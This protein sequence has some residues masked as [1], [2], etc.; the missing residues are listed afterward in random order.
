MHCKPFLGETCRAGIRKLF[1]F[2]KGDY[3]IFAPKPIGNIKLF[4]TE[5]ASDKKGCIKIGPCGLG[6]RAVYLNSFFLDR[7]CYITYGDIRRIYKRIAMTKNGFS[8]K[9]AFG[10]MPYLVV[11]KSDGTEKQCNFKYEYEVDSFINKF[12]ETHPGIPIFSEAG[13]KRLAEE[14][15]REE[16]RYVKNLSP[17]ALSS[18]AELERA[19]DFLRSDPAV[20]DELSR[21]AK[22]KRIIDNIKPAYK[23]FA[24]VIL[25]FSA[26]ACIY[27]IYSV[28]NG[29]GMS[30]YF[31]L[32]GFAFMF[33][34]MSMQ[35]LP[36]AKN[37]SKAAMREFKKAVLASEEFISRYNNSVC[38]NGKVCAF[39]LPAQYAHPAAISRMIRIIREGRA[40]D[41]HS[42]YTAMKDELKTINNTV[43]VSQTE[44]DEITAV[45]PMFLICG[46]NDNFNINEVL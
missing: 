32:F 33:Y 13:E 17:E 16:K 36:T 34:A 5:L 12:H 37:N 1:D 25:A 31:I 28:M 9:G 39:P 29:S 45:K 6:K 44:Y 30:V 43:K 19:A 7:V 14:R 8:G 3:M 2:I 26:A 18:I 11:L 35:V 38:G 27:G 15:A 21:T 42:A 24:T 10:T 46:Y 41:I 20:C 23:I 4:E 40:S 22:Q